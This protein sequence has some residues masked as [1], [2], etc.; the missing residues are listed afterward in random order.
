MENIIIKIGGS[1][2][3]D[4]S[5][6]LN[7]VFLN[8]IINWSKSQGKYKTIIFVVGGGKLS[9]FLVNQVQ[10]DIQKDYLKHTIGMRITQ[11]NATIFHS[12]FNDDEVKYFSSLDLL[13]DGVQNNQH[14][15]VVIGGTKVGGSTDLVASEIAFNLGIG[16]VNKISNIEYIYTDDPKVNKDAKP[17]KNITWGEYIKIFYEDYADGHK[18]GMSVP[19]DFK[20]SEFCKKNNISFRVSGGDNLE[21]KEIDMILET[22]TV[23]K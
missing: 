16:C 19:I 14:K 20:C 6:S 23:V 4:E 15:I 18:P 9:R 3:Y 22:G 10:E 12:M 8:K 21:K 7:K 2:L 11:L 13:Y 17:L 1:L 5:L